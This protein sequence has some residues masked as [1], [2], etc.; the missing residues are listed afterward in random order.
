MEGRVQERFSFC[1]QLARE[2]GRAC[3]RRATSTRLA[4]KLTRTAPSAS[5]RTC[6]E[7]SGVLLPRADLDDGVSPDEI[8]LRQVDGR[9]LERGSQVTAV[10]D[11]EHLLRRYR[12][13]I[14]DP[15]RSHDCG[16]PVG[17][18]RPL[19]VI[20]VGSTTNP[21]VMRGARAAEV[22][23]VVGAQGERESE[24]LP[25]T[26]SWTGYLAVCNL[27]RGAISQWW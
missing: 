19:D 6:V 21:A 23:A 14:R 5:E 20:R 15:T 4:S 26:R 13:S 17:C 16:E 25:R 8:R 22:P 11:V 3:R 2:F 9:L 1:G 27:A 7:C 18:S 12:H 10:G 24:G